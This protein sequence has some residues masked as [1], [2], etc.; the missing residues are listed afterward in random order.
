MCSETFKQWLPSG[1]SRLNRL[2]VKEDFQPGS[3][4]L[5]LDIESAVIMVIK[6]NLSVIIC[7]YLFLEKV[8]NDS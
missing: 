8:K 4:D 2:F 7:T 1:K 6:M 3:S 5:G